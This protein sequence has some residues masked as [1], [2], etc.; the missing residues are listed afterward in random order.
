M[1]VEDASLAGLRLITPQRIVDG[2]VFFSETY[3]QHTLAERGINY[4]FVQ[5]NHSL[6][7]SVG[8]VRGLHFQCPPRAR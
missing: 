2:R 4:Q 1:K 8:V 3:R 7:M 5:D 6:S